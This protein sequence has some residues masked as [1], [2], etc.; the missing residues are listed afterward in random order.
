MLWRLLSV[1]F[2][3]T[4]SQKLKLIKFA[5]KNHH[6]WESEIFLG[7]FWLKSDNQ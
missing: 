7:H 2:E 5:E 6:I 4:N 3:P 1:L